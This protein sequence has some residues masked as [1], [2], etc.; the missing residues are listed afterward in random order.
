MN[1]KNEQ[2]DDYRALLLLDE[3][4][5]KDKLT[6]RDLSKNL[7]I[8]LGLI[9]SYIKN[10]VSKGYITVSAIPKNRYKYYLTPFGLRE[11]TRL[12]YHHLQNFTNLYRVARRDFKTLF[13]NIAKSGIKRITLCGV[14]EIAEI[15]Y[16]S[17]TE[18][19]LEL[20][21]FVDDNNAGKKFFGYNVISVEDIN[22]LK[23]DLIVIT[24]FDEEN[25]LLRKLRDM[26]IK[27]EKICNTC[28]GGWLR[29]VEEDR[30]GTYQPE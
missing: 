13:H 9:N 17:L 8:A 4:S 3:I 21:G 15:A 16:L 27:E 24:S 18:V 14:D 5:K 30:S 26:G 25:V 19:D 23:F 2:V 7:G 28:K 22:N 6:Q 12:T 29:K 11:K 10:L 1:N 20:V